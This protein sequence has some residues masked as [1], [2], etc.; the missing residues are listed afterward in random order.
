MTVEAQALTWISF[1]LWCSLQDGSY[2]GFSSK[3]FSDNLGPAN[4][5]QQKGNLL[6]CFSIFY[7]A[8]T[9]ILAGASLSGDLK[10]PAE[11][12][13]KG[14]LYAMATA[15]FAYLGIFLL[16]AATVK[17]EKLIRDYYVVQQLCVAEEVTKLSRDVVMW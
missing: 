15:V 12:I 14:T 1:I 5:A 9:G 13:P 2:T 4:A 3:T 10:K 7:P 8:L 6:F 17:R 11:S 16:S